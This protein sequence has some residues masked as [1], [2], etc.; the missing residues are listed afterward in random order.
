MHPERRRQPRLAAAYF[1]LA[2]SEYQATQERDPTNFEALNRYAHVFWEWRHGEA[3]G[4]PAGGPGTG[5]G[6]TGG[7][8][9][10]EGD[11]DDRGQA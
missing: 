1:G 7:V 8:E 10:P 3:N 6:A 5:A 2:L 9:C 4:K 11:R